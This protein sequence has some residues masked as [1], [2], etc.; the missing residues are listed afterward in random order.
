MFSTIT[1]EPSTNIPIATAIP[2]N[3]IKFADKPIQD[4]TIKAIAIEIGIEI[5][6][7]KVARKFIK[8]RASTI[9]ININ[10]SANAC[11]TV[12]TALVI[13]SA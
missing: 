7:K 1:T 12:S 11:T 9:T 10:A 13:K 4:I 3:D 5:N 6:T 2:P 8:N